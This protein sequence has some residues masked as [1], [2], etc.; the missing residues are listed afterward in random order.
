MLRYCA[1]FATAS[2]NG[3]G[4]LAPSWGLDR[5]F[6]VYE[7][8]AE[9]DGNELGEDTLRERLEAATPWIEPASSIGNI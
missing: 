9:T 5:G 2:F 8:F 3:G 6:D 7:S 4:Q 1:C